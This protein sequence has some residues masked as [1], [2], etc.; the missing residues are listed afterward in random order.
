MKN[1]P[2]LKALFQNSV[3]ASLLLL[4]LILLLLQFPLARL[5]SLIAERQHSQWQVQQEVTASW[6]GEQQI[7]G[8]YLIVPWEESA[9]TS[10]RFNM[11]LPDTERRY[12]VLLPS[13]LNISAHA[14]PEVRYRGLYEV[15]LYQADITVDAEFS[16]P[17][18]AVFAVKPEQWQWQ[19]ARVVMTLSDLKALTGRIEATWQQTAL[20]VMPGSS[21][22]PAGFH[23]PLKDPFAQADTARFTLN[24]SLNGSQRLM[25]TP[26][27]RSSVIQME[28]TWPTPG[29]QG[30]WLPSQRTV[31]EQGFTAQWDIP[32]IARGLPVQWQGLSVDL[33]QSELHWVGVQL[34]PAVDAYR[35]T[36]RATKYQL[37]FL[38][39]IFGFFWLF[40]TLAGVAVQGLHYVLTGGSVCLFYLLLLSLAEHLGFVSAYLCA[41]GAVITQMTLYGKSVLGGWC[42]AGGLGLLL[43]S[44]FAY[45]WS[46]LQEQ[47][48]AL[49]LGSVGLFA[50]L[51]LVM[52]LTRKRLTPA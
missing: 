32:F 11:P 24:F 33:K 29:F 39:M 46:L 43:A 36:E 20:E 48:Y 25:V 52:F 4:G 26:L 7:A 28:G 2:S 51:S 12:A 1:L 41:S 40:Q 50:G 15:P 17:D 14:R 38:L 44:L 47:D 30:E 27:G 23:F 35:Q 31:T 3:T 18:P 5:D 21:A 42:R 34:Q 10:L 45:L 9:P 8:P 6:G 22:A 16:R 37:L 49:L 13:R 19:E